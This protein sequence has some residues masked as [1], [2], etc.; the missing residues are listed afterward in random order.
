MYCM[1]L[2]FKLD[3]DAGSIGLL[4]RS[5]ME[6]MVGGRLVGR[7]SGQSGGQQGFCVVPVRMTWLRFMKCELE[8]CLLNLMS[9]SKDGNEREVV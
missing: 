7:S 6:R 4:Y 9:V 3:W 2:L 8:T 1:I 5:N